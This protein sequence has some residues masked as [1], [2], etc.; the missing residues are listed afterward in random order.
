MYDDYNRYNDREANN[1]YT[2]LCGYVISFQFSE[3]IDFF[4]LNNGSFISVKKAPI[5][6]SF[7]RA[8]PVF[9]INMTQRIGLGTR[10]WKDI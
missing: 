7:L 9:N 4:S 3:K 8:T 10:K 6:L 2:K 1:M 5:Q